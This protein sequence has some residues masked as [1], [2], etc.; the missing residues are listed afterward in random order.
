MMAG[1][2]PTRRYRQFMR[3]CFSAVYFV[4]LWFPEPTAFPTFT[5]ARRILA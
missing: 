1:T 4:L 2:G 3:E 5:R